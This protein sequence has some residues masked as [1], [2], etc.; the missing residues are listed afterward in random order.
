[1]ISHKEC[2]SMGGTASGEYLYRS[3]VATPLRQRR[4]WRLRT[5]LPSRLKQTSSIWQLRWIMNT[6]AIKTE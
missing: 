6:C 5:F 1:M 3:V 2:N 4:K